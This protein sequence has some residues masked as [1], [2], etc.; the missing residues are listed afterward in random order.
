MITERELSQARRAREAHRQTLNAIESRGQQSLADKAV[1]EID[2]LKVSH[3]SS[4]VSGEFDE[5][6]AMNKLGGRPIAN[7]DLISYGIDP[8]VLY[9][10]NDEEDPEPRGSFY[11]FDDGSIAIVDNT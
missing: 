1:A 10:L 4:G 8:G 9:L 11:G 7:E 3:L 6:E 2:D 5:H